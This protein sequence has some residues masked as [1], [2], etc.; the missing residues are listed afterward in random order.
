MTPQ[1]PRPKISYK[2]EDPSFT[3]QEATWILEETD[4]KDLHFTFT[5]WDI[6]SVGSTGREILQINNANRTFEEPSV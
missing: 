4:N 3:S 6:A 5:Y 1:P 2:S